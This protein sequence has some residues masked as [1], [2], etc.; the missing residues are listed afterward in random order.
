MKRSFLKNYEINLK[1]GNESLTRVRKTAEN[2]KKNIK[3]SWIKRNKSIKQKSW[4]LKQNLKM[5]ELR[6][7][8]KKILDID[9]FRMNMSV[10]RNKFLKSINN[11]WK[12]LIKWSTLKANIKRLDLWRNKF[13][14]I[15]CSLM[16]KKTWSKRE[17]KEKFRKEWKT[18][19]KHT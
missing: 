10:K 7:K 11:K 4:N 19:G 17:L 18:W 14:S 5:K 2:S 9:N 3:K 16:I 8:F 13:K 15:N 1:I 12:I 6:T